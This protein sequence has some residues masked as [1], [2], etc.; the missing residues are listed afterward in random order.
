[1]VPLIS[2]TYLIQNHV[3]NNTLILLIYH[4]NKLILPDVLCPNE[5]IYDT[6]KQ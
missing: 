4:L 3:T 6:E 2:E 5:T 1:M